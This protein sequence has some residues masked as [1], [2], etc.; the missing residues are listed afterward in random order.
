MPITAST[1]TLG[2][3]QPDGRRPVIE[4]HTASTGLV[5]FVEYLATAGT[6]YTLV[7]TA[8]A[9]L[10][11]D[12]LADEEARG[13][14]GGALTLQHQ[15]K[16]QYL[17]NLR[18]R[19]MRSVREDTCRLAHRMLKHITDNDC[20]PA[21][22]RTAWGMTVADWTAKA[23]NLQLKADKWNNLRSAENAMNSEVGD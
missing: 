2:P 9:A 3:V 20:T 17:L 4:R 11:A 19:Y 16:A 7:M 23:T 5:I 15:T 22:M 14:N 12:I 18:V 21:E 10:L 8:R 1:L 13:M 6:D